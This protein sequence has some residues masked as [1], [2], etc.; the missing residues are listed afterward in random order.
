MKEM[1]KRIDKINYYLDVAETISERGTCFRKNY[2]SIIVKND[3]IIST[4][5]T[6]APRGRKNCIDLGYCTRR[7]L[8]PDAKNGTRF[9]L[10]R[11]VHSEMNAII[12][13]ARKD[14]IG[15]TLYMVGKY[16]PIKLYNGE[17]AGKYA[18]D[19]DCCNFCKRLIINSGIEKVI[20]RIDKKKYKEINVND[21]IDYD[22]LLEGKEGY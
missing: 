19:P 14:M 13:A 4:G 18:K 3:E 7:K 5:Y 10:C 21:W 8:F 1:F 17:L 15:A 9:D 22:E 2:G 12:S 16:S 11:S 6:G 20:I